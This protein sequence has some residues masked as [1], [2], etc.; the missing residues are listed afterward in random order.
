M[1]IVPFLYCESSIGLYWLEDIP[2]Q[3]WQIKIDQDS[4]VCYFP[5][6]GNNK[7]IKISWDLL[8]LISLEMTNNLS[9]LF[10]TFNMKS[11]YCK[12]KHMFV[13]KQIKR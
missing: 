4:I 3:C 11:E 6:M 10:K 5:G 12:K 9:H 13:L 2:L 8:F 1:N 7:E